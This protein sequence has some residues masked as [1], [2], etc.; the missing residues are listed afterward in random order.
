ML[1]QMARQDP[2]LKVL[3]AVERDDALKREAR[4][5]NLDR[6]LR[7]SLLRLLRH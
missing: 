3:P 4:Y 7:R 5:V 2:K 1:F 6:W